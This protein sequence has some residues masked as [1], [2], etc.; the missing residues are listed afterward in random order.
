[1]SYK[2]VGQQRKYVYE[3]SCVDI[4]CLLADKLT[5]MIDNATDSNYNAMLRNCKGLLEW[6]RE[7]GYERS[8]R[9][10]LTLKNDWHVSYH[11]STFMGQPCFYLVWSAIEFIWVRKEG[12]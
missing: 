7:K 1:M 11:R 8:V 12:T 3:T 6:A 9:Q 10:G 5:E 4:S 2:A